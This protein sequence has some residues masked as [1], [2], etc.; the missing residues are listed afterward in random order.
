MCDVDL[1]TGFADIKYQWVMLKAGNRQKK[2]RRVS[3]GTRGTATHAETQA[4]EVPSSKSQAER[5][6]SYLGLSRKQ[7]R[8]EKTRLRG[9]GEQFQYKGMLSAVEEASAIEMRRE[10]LELRAPSQR[11]IDEMNV[12]CEAARICGTSLLGAVAKKKLPAS[13]FR[14]GSATYVHEADKVCGHEG[15]CVTQT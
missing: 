4:G 14:V 5:C 15:T 8:A 11:Y 2:S 1:S 3:A 7:L 6:V 13:C 10:L 9:K 12:A